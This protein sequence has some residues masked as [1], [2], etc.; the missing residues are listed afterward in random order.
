MSPCAQEGVTQWS[1]PWLLSYNQNG[2]ALYI[3]EALCSILKL[4]CWLNPNVHVME[5]TWVVSSKAWPRFAAL[6]SLMCIS[7]LFIYLAALGLNCSTQDQVPWPGIEPQ[8][9]VL[10]ARSLS[11][12]TT[13]EVPI[14]ISC[15]SL[16]IDPSQFRSI[17]WP[18]SVG[19]EKK[20]IGKM[21]P[22]VAFWS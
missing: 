7:Y 3:S 22:N 20:K 18:K 15:M 2:I 1:L 13:R 8:L 21:G 4:I 17:H 19:E 12:W 14:S 6:T 16:F 5:K 9:P 10:E 11:H